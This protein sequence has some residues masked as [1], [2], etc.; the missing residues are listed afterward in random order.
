MFSSNMY[1]VYLMHELYVTVV[2]PVLVIVGDYD[3]IVLVYSA[4]YFQFCL[5]DPCFKGV[6]G[7]D[8]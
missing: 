6:S 1:L 8:A 5:L 7:R 2:I 3:V 4:Q